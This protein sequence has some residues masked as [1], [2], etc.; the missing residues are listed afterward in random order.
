MKVLEKTL[1]DYNGSD[2]QNNLL[3]PLGLK[4]AKTKDFGSEEV[5]K[6]SGEVLK[7]L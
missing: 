1:L 7:R 2:G 4:R 6:S 5:F 3:E